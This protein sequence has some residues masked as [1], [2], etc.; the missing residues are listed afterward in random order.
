V[1]GVRVLGSGVDAGAGLAVRDRPGADGAVG[2]VQSEWRAARDLKHRRGLVRN[3]VGV[4]INP[5]SG[6]LTQVPGSPFA[7]GEGPASV[8]FSPSGGLL[9]TANY[10]DSVSVFSVGS[11]G[12]LTPVP[13]SPFAG[14]GAALMGQVSVAF[15]PGGGL[16]A[17]TTPGGNGPV[18]V[19]SVDQAT[20]A[21]TPVSGSPFATGQGPTESAAFSPGGGLLATANSR[22]RCPESSALLSELLCTRAGSRRPRLS[23]EQLRHADH[24]L[25]PCGSG[26]PHAAPLVLLP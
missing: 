5:T 25:R 13:G 23:W 4:L 24:T 2:G 17:T 8:A 10:D 12:A 9:A 1:S 26:D 6:A 14:G 15:S 18:T 7:T 20:G 11:S 21:L 16:L 3:R 22:C 19:F